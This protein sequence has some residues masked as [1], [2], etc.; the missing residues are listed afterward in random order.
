MDRKSE[1]KIII[2]H[3]KADLHTYYGRYESLLE[4][5]IVEYGVLIKKYQ[6]ELS[7][8]TQKPKTP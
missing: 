8:L 4:G 5:K 6:D 3:L 2:Q 7:D 1:I